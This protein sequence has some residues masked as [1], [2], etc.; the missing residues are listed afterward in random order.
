[1]QVSLSPQEL[2]QNS[3]LDLMVEL[4]LIPSVPR[5]LTITAQGEGSGRPLNTLPSLGVGHHTGV[6]AHI[7]WLYFGNV[8]IS[9]FL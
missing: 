7:P 9:R 6:I 2:I 4:Y 1:M 8:Q 3:F 5:E